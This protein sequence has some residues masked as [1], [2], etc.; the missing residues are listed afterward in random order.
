MIRL[1]EFKE[2]N[3]INSKFFSEQN[4]LIKKLDLD[5]ITLNSIKIPFITLYRIIDILFKNNSKNLLISDIVLLTILSV[6][7]LSKENSD[8]INKLKD[9]LSDRKLQNDFKSVVN[10]VM[11]IKNLGNIILK[12]EGI[13]IRNI[14]HFLKYK[15]SIQVLNSL[16]TYVTINKINIKEFAFSFV[17]D[18]RSNFSR[19]ILDYIKLNLE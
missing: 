8:D 16:L 7:I 19:K 13:I 10:S 14:E 2:Y 17:T 5:L 6:S 4:K 11:S 12:N 9:E 18:N 3:D 1:F 15:S